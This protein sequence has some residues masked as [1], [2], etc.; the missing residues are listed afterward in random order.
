MNMRFLQM[1]DKY[2]EHNWHKDIEF[3]REFEFCMGC[4]NAEL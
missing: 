2:I 1:A 3:E 4:Q